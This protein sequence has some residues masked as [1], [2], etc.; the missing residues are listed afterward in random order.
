VASTA[1]DVPRFYLDEDIP[2]AAAAIGSS[3]G[4]DIVATKD[5]NQSLPQDDAAHL[6]TAARDRRV[7]VTYNRDDFLAATRDAFASA[8]PHA[9]LLILTHKLPRDAGRLARALAG[10]VASRRADDTWPLQEYEVDFL[11]H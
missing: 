5:A 2:Y 8:A 9:G 7:M 1:P 3:L 4:L 11:S 10:W 6:R